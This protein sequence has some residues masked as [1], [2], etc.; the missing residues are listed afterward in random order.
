V[1]AESA[2][3]GLLAAATRSPAQTAPAAVLGECGAAGGPAVVRLAGLL[4]PGFLADAGWNPATGVLAPP[5]GHRLIRWDGGKVDARPGKARLGGREAPLPVLGGDKCA[6]L[7]CLRPRRV[8]HQ[9]QEAHCAV[10]AAR[11]EEARRAG[12]AF[13]ERSWNRTAEPVPVTGQVNLRGLAPLV[14]AEL[15][16]GLQQ[17]AGAEVTSYCRFLRRLAQELRQTQVPSL[18]ELP[19]QD[20]PVRRSLVN[21]L[22]AHLG[23]AFADPRTEIA[24]DRWDLT[25]LGHHGWLTFTGISQDWLREAA[26]GWAAHDLPRRRGKQAGA[27]LNEVTGALVRLSATLRAGR[28]D[29]GQDPAGLGRADIEAFLH[30]M[31][32]LSANG[33]LSAYSRVKTCQDA[34]RVLTEIRSLGLTRTGSPAAGLPD[35]FTLTTGDVPAKADPG[36]PGRDIPAE[37]MR[38]ICGHLPELEE[39]VSSRETRIAVELLIDTGRRPAEICT[40]EWDCLAGDADGTPV[41]VYDNSK[42][43]RLRRRLPVSEHT[44]TLITDQKL[45]V[46]ERFPATPP[47]QLKLLPSRR[48]NPVGS[49]PVTE[50]NLIG[51]HR[52][53]L[54]SMGPL[55]RADGTEFDKALITPYSYRHSYAQRHA[56]AGVP[57][58]VLRELMD[59]TSMDTTKRYYRVGETRRR[60]AVDKVTA[61]QFDRHGNRVWRDAATLL[62]SEHARYAIGTV[63]VPYGTCGEP[64]NVKAG[65]GACPVRFR[66]AGCDHFRTDVSHLPDLTGYLD[67]LLRTRERLAATVEGVDEWARADATPAGEEITRIRRLISKIKGDITQLT[68]VERAAVDDAVA[69]VRRHRSARSPVSLGMPAS[70]T[71]LPSPRTESRT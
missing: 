61:M 20:E 22:V 15:L 44:A 8:R 9:R 27:R 31:A 33:Q 26:K 42:A 1:S 57:I 64:S 48:L 18:A 4:D 10:H 70:G 54:S 49:R 14:V 2:V 3:G 17:R 19:V 52:I 32:F 68:D 60:Q 47:A 11:W 41:L 25:V 46:R 35:D 36:E 38:Q 12:L 7:A 53:W 69:V 62:D 51:R 16:Y 28:P 71:P 21:S 39:T 56:D 45:A 23:R 37:I 13:D 59:H 5:A 67:D 55:P 6:V 40:L 30:R 58:D 29:Q 34:G 66:C 43:H 50:D 63:A 24:K 65:G